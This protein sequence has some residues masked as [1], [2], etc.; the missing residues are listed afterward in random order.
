MSTLI[1]CLFIA[2]LLPYASRMPVFFAM[3]KM[4]YY[5][6]NNPREQQAKL[7]GFGARA[8]AAH[9]NSFESLLIFS[10]AVLTA[11]VTQH[12]DM[13]MRVL[14]IVY[15]VSRFIYHALYLMDKASLRSLVWA[16]G[17]ICCLAMLWMCIP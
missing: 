11:L 13:V 9:Q 10:T 8:V 12:V 14:A 6:N 16:V 2:V 3:K 5:D 15:L 1:I 4:G 7:Q 17:L